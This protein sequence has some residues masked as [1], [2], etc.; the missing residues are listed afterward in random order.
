MNEYLPGQGIMPHEDGNAYWPVTATVSLLGST[1]LE[2]FEKKR[3]VGEEP[4][5]PVAPA[6]RIFQERRSLLITMEPAYHETLHGISEVEEDG[7]LGPQTIANWNLLRLASDQQ[8]SPDGSAVR[9]D[10]R[11]SLT[12]RDVRKVSNVAGRI[13]G[14]SK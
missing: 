8:M 13:F 12:Y 3:Q 2:V 10:T 9:R 14:R 4:M 11:V 7:C 6:W 5:I 1:V